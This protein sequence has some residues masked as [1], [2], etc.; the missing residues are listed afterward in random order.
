MATILDKMVNKKILI[1]DDDPGNI[2]LL[3]TILSIDGYSILKAFNGFDGI[4]LA[5]KNL[6]AIILLNIKMPE[7]DGFKVCQQL[8]ENEATCSIPVIFT[9]ELIDE[10]SIIK[11]FQSGGSDFISKP[12][13]QNE[14]LARIEAHHTMRDQLLRIEEQNIALKLEISRLQEAE[15][16][17]KEREERYRI[18]SGI[19]TDYI[20]STILMPD[21]SLDLNWVVGAF[22]SISGYPFE[23]FKA[24]GGW[25]AT[26]HP[27]DIHIDDRDITKLRNK[28]DIESEIRTYNKAGEIVWVHVFAHPIWDEKNDHLSGIYGAVKNITDRKHSEELLM[29]SEKR[30]R[31]LLE[32]VQ[33][34]SVILDLDGK[35]IFANDFLIERTGYSKDELIGADWFDTMIP[36]GLYEVKKLFLDG[37]KSGKIESNFENPIITKNG[38]LL[39]IVWSNVIQRNS[40]NMLT[41]V[42]SIG[43]DVSERKRATE[44]L[45]ILNLELE[46]RVS[47][48]TKELE[49][50][51][52]SVSHDLK[53]PL[54]AING[55]VNILIEDYGTKIDDEGKRICGIIQSNAIKMGQLIDDLLSFSRLIRSEV[56]FSGIDMESLVKKILSE[57]ESVQNIKTHDII[58]IQDLPKTSG[59]VNL[60]KQVWTNLISNA[61]KYSGKSEN[62]SIT[63]GAFSKDTETVYFIKDNGVG[64]SMN[65][66]HKLFDVFQRLHT[67]AEFE[68]TGVGLAIVKRIISRHNGH[69]WAEGEIGKGAVFYFSLPAINS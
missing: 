47:E 28:Q 30:F 56:N 67:T 64:F 41:S 25:R 43:E 68:G 2:L 40:N 54:R 23:E 11:G 12:Y 7:M 60:I 52:Y 31:E 42:A 61:L 29:N 17:L 14:L 59:D 27:D 36:N 53:A 34:I 26:I 38:K 62:P 33:L 48:R 57:L 5:K 66:A 32:K 21:G 10:D 9:S 39:D 65:Y 13:N 20:F 50:F 18:I 51:S 35:I 44:E 1:I 24:R 16:N 49:A 45:R 6:S 8:K 15:D 55:F 37:L 58:T 4:E 3:E 19:S 63:I 46:H 22:E 69:V